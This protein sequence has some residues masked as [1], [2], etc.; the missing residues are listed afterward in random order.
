VTLQGQAG[1]SNLVGGAG[2]DTLIA[3]T[4]PDT[5]TGAGGADHFVFQQAPW[6]AGH[7]TDF[8]HGVDKID[9]S[10]LLASVHYAGS[11]PIA[12]G[13]IKLL[14]S[15]SGATWLYF[16]SDGP[17]SADQWGSFLTTID[18]VTPSGL[19]ASDFIV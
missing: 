10:T 7:I 13:Y 4:G 19:S 6:N 14:D 16:D 17:G 8:A 5:M 2:T 3:G 11:N 9:V 15:G 18:K 1:G 12:D